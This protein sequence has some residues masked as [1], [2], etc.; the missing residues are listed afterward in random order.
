MNDSQQEQFTG[1]QAYN[2]LL[3]F[4]RTTHKNVYVMASH[5][6]YVMN[7][8]Y[9]TACHAKDDVLPGWIVGSGGAVRYRLP[10]DLGQSTIAR[11]DVY[12]YVIANVA[13]DYT[14]AF[15]F[16]PVEEKDVPKSVHDE[17]GGEQVRWC[18]KNNKSDYQVPGPTCPI[19]SAH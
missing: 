2:A 5:S 18:F 14:V 4:R 8:I 19:G 15:E 12:G 10:K 13:P 9:A 11:T 6:H 17:F 16:K 3:D 1:R 7:D